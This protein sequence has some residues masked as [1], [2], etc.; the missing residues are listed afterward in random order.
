MIVAFARMEKSLKTKP[1]TG[2]FRGKQDMLN[3]YRVSVLMNPNV[4]D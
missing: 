4:L 1:I 2:F 3:K